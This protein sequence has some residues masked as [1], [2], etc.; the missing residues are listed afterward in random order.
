MALYKL[1]DFIGIDS[2]DEVNNDDI[3]HFASK[4]N[5]FFYIYHLFH[6]VWNKILCNSYPIF[7]SL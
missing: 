7:Y 4:P 2:V 3:Q 6:K 5:S 1:Y